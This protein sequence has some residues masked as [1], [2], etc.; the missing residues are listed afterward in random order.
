[1]RTTLGRS[2]LMCLFAMAATVAAADA[3][4]KQA[5][6][7]GINDIPKTF[8]DAV[9]GGQDFV[10]RVAMIP[11][12]DG[13]KLYTVIML[14]KGAHDAPILL[15]R[16]PY[17]ADER[18]G[19]AT[20][21]S[22][23]SAL[24]L[25][26]AV[27]AQAG[28]I[29]VYQDVRGKY[30]SEGD[31]VMMRPVRGPLNPTKVDHV[32]DAWDT[33]DWLVKHVPES[34]G[35]VAMIGSSYEGFTAAM[36]LLD[37]HPALKASVP[38]SPVIDAYMG[39]D[40]FH[41]GAFRN[42]MLGYVHMQTV[43]KGAGAV[44]PS[45]TYD[46]YEEYL[47]AGSTGDYVRS[48]GLD[49]L[50]FTARVMEHPA[51]DA[52]W[53]G[54]DL[55]RL[56]AAHPSSVPTLWEQGLFDQEDMWGA[57][58]AWLALKAAGH[59]SNNWLVLGPWSHSQVNGTGFALGPL[60]WSGDTALEYNRDMV[61]PFLEH[62]LRDK[63]AAPLAHVSVYNTGDNRW[64]RFEDWPTACEH[65]CVNA[66]K[67]LYLGKDFGLSFAAP[68]E[69]DAGDSYV[70]DPARPVP[71]LP[72]PVLDPFFAYG[73]TYAGYLPWSKWL[74]SDQRFV[75]G[76]TDVLVYETPVLTAPVRVQGIPVADVR[77]ATT[78]TDGDVVVKLIDVYPS[79][80]THDPSM[81][82][83]ELPI[84]LDIFRGRYRESFEHPSAIPAN[85]PQRYRFELP[86]VNHVFQP[87]HR[88]MVQIQSSLFPLYDRN[89]QTFVPNIFEAKPG[90]YRAATITVL[91]S[92]AQPS[93]VWL[94]VV[95]R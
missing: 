57:N 30:G 64:D 50:P 16:T 52:F 60:K 23:L 51:Y 71:F 14:P 61:L 89:P 75:D 6:L 28:Y 31:Y 33:I 74:V 18:A 92:G 45:D 27:F 94:P 7:Y 38:E 55:V 58:H 84:A 79:Q 86:N 32:T 85:Q 9:P 91:R 41:H 62:Y 48:R 68:T 4:R 17:N 69:A 40:W 21:S 73:S 78:G 83:Y 11:M 13:V 3:P 35:R 93:A 49:K 44:T 66:L 19:N 63:P 26:D 39:D 12:R 34:N 29:R 1:M 82:G 46:K 80:V 81:G 90:D 65:G 77:A 54:Q 20:S 25:G 2:L 56:L 36:A 8:D 42:L 22:L 15:T 37:P 59:A 5:P 10:K 24:P 43:Q 72:R 87:G 67:P 88:I 47:R 76:R 53:Q 70:S 95:E